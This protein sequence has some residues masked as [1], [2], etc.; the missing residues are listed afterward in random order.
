MT[1]SSKTSAQ[2][3][4]MKYHVGNTLV[5]YTTSHV[6]YKDIRDGDVA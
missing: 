2:N 4:P 1:R 5:I 6:N 3:D